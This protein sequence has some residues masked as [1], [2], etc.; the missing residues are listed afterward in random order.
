MS[1]PINPASADHARDAD[2]RYAAAARED[3]LRTIRIGL[4]LDAKLYGQLLTLITDRWPG[5]T[6]AGGGIRIPEHPP[7]RVT[8][9]IEPDGTARSFTFP[10]PPPL[11]QPA[12]PH[13]DH[14]ANDAHNGNTLPYDVLAQMLHE[15]EHWYDIGRDEAT[16]R[17]RPLVNAL[18]ELLERRQRERNGE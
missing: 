1:D 9:E 11:P 15:V 10:L 12:A 4:P 3:E 18:T 8:A 2:A 5:S 16:L 17:T 13:I 14:P 6:L 7:E